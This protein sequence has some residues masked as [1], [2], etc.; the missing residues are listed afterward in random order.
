V[1]VLHRA[2]IRVEDLRPANCGVR[3]A[4]TP[5][6]AQRCAGVPL[7]NVAISVS[8]Q[9]QPA[10][11][12]DAMITAHGLEGGPIYAL[13][14][15]IRRSLDA[16][17]AA[18]QLDLQPDLSVAQVAVRLAKRRPKDSLSTLLRRTV[19]LSPVAIDIM[20]EATANRLPS[21]TVELAA[22]VKSMP[23][24][25]QGV[26]PIA[27][28]ISTAGGVAFDEIDE[29]FMLR[30]L[31]SVFVVGE[32][33]DWEAPTGGYLLQATFSTAVAA[34]AGALAYVHSAVV[35]S[36]GSGAGR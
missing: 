31:P 27:R 28:A 26:M 29:S 12:G 18:L 24:P 23:L 22:L 10:V 19:G 25:V 16:G 34:A 33:L 3:I 4:W 1:A 14:A 11:R 7:K 13:G 8:E 17:G 20:R 6:F 5:G 32:M 21:S 36:P 2:G 15:A 35:P 9:A 30:A